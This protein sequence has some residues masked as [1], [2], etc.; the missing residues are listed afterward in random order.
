VEKQEG[1][2][3]DWENLEDYAGRINVAQSSWLA[4]IVLTRSFSVINRVILTYFS[5]GLIFIIRRLK[6]E[7]KK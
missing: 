3:F 1:R 2:S 7:N 5:A 4:R 6:N